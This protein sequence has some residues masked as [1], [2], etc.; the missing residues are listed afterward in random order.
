MI[1]GKKKCCYPHKHLLG[2]EGLEPPSIN[3]LLSLSEFFV[4]NL[5]GDVHSVALNKLIKLK[6]NN[7]LE[8][9]DKI[10]YAW[11]LKH[12]E[13]LFTL[14]NEQINSLKINENRNQHQIKFA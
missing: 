12:L 3:Y 4:D 14:T 13:F 9:E 10:V 2:I 11:N 7:E 8:W 5:N 1:E 6:E